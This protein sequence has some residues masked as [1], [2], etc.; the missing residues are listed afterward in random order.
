MLLA[1]L[2]IFLLV[3]AAVS[4]Q[5]W[6]KDWQIYYGLAAGI[7]LGLA[8]LTRPLVVVMLPLLFPL[9]LLQ[10]LNFRTSAKRFLIISLIV[11]ATISPWTMRN[12]LVH[13]DFVLITT[14]AGYNLYVGNNPLATGGLVTPLFSDEQERIRDTVK[15]SNI[16]FY[17]YRWSLDYILNNPGR[18]LSLMASKAK[19]ILF[20][21]SVDEAKYPELAFLVFAVIGFAVTVKQWRRYAL[22]YLI[23]A[24]L[25]LPHLFFFA[26]ARF[27]LPAVPFLAVFA[28]ASIVW[29]AH[30]VERWTGWS[31]NSYESSDAVQS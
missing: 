26:E 15:A 16:D 18:S 6:F 11:F 24:A 17:Y 19:I 27:R 2:F 29:I 14:N 30:A 31:V 9:I 20:D 12:Y 1:H 23:T 21:P 4:I 10:G 22:I 5:R 3:A 7:L 8:C 13:D 25:V 28:A